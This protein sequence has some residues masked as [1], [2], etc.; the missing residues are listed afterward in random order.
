[1]NEVEDE[2]EIYPENW[3]S[4]LLLCIIFVMLKRMLVF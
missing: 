3:V 2:S 1:M 4:K